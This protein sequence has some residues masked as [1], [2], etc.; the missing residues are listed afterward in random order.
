MTIAITPI[1][2]TII[3]A[4]ATPDT[5]VSAG[6]GGVGSALTSARGDHDHPGTDLVGGPAAS[7]DDELA[8]FSG[9]GGKTLQ[10]YTSDGPTVND[11]GESVFNALVNLREGSAANSN[12]AIRTTNTQ[13]VSTTAEISPGNDQGGFAIVSGRDTADG[14][15]R[16]I[17]VVLYGR[18]AVFTV[19]GTLNAFG[20]PEAR[21]YSSSGAGGNLQVAFASRTFD[22]LVLA[23]APAIPT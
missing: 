1:P 2:T 16:F 8:R 23:F 7:V 13:N 12:Q 18:G 20:A 17:N 15:L 11:T 9:V 14:A 3:Y 5:V 10:D 6:A 19:V 4:T 21:T 22:I